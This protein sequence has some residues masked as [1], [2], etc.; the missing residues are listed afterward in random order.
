MTVARKCA[1]EQ[2]AN[3]RGPNCACAGERDYAF[4]L[5]ECAKRVEFTLRL[6]D[7]MSYS[8]SG[9][10]LILSSLFASPYSK[11]TRCRPY[12][13]R[14]GT[15]WFDGKTTFSESLLKPATYVFYLAGACAVS[16]CSRAARIRHQMF[17][18]GLQPTARPMSYTTEGIDTKRVTPA[19]HGNCEDFHANNLF[20]IVERC[21]RTTSPY[22][23]IP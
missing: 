9:S 14:Q 16:E 13:K 20:K 3:V 5:Q 19:G 7:A 18:V 23:L 8:G 12:R 17:A 22:L 6:W 4:A 15:I 11:R 2:S 10:V 21:A 1:R